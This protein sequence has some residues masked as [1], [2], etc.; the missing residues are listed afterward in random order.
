MSAGSV[1]P[2]IEVETA[3]DL[4][5]HVGSALGASRWVTVTQADIDAFAALTGD[6]HWIHVDG[7]RAAREMPGGATIAHGLHLLS[8][9]PDLQRDIYAV[10]RRGRGLNYGYDR[11]RFTDTVPVG[12]RVRLSLTLVEVAP[13]RAGTR[14]VTEATIERE[15]AEKP[16]LVARHLLLIEG[17]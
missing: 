17:E 13:H 14:L 3:A 16:A 4:A 15:G 6:D 9:I 2:G 12:S 11:V 1:K 5:A 7:E 10:R 8:L